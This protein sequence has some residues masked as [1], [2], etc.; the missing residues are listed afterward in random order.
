MGKVFSKGKMTEKVK[1]RVN[2]EKRAEITKIYEKSI[3]DLRKKIE[4]NSDFLTT[5]E[6][7]NFLKDNFE[8]LKKDEI[9]LDIED[10]KDHRKDTG[11]EINNEKLKDFEDLQD[12][13]Y[14]ALYKEVEVGKSLNSEL[15]K[16]INNN[17]EG[18][19]FIT[20]DIKKSVEKI[21]E[22]DTNLFSVSNK[23]LLEEKFK[24][25]SEKLNSKQRTE[26]SKIKVLNDTI[27][28]I[29]NTIL[30][31]NLEKKESN[32][33]DEVNKIIKRRK[34]IAAG[35]AQVAVATIIGAVNVIMYLIKQSETISPTNTTNPPTNTTKLPTN[36]TTPKPSTNTTKPPV[37]TDSLNKDIM[38]ILSLVTL[39]ISGCYMVRNNGVNIEAIRLEGCSNWYNNIE[40]QFF[41]G[42]PETTEKKELPDCSKKELC[43][44]PF[45]LK[46]NSN[47]NIP[48][49]EICT[50]SNSKEKLYKC[51]GTSI[52]DKDFVFY[53]YQFYTPNSV[54]DIINS[55]GEETDNTT[56]NIFIIVITVIGI[57]LTM[58]IIYFIMKNKVS[59]KKL[60][61]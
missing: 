55:L 11:Q 25:L 15:V 31:D 48:D 16:I 38:Y 19:K 32:I 7:N 4:T 58:L 41:C 21:Y 46:Q 14:D 30:F 45:C 6:I 22:K 10:Y 2:S 33:T 17:T 35:I 47:C 40:N 52:N 13:Y 20:Q 9:N 5:D 44:Y 36:T 43:N 29:T 23:A 1:N 61:K 3:N 42:C 49:A 28:D 26:D 56:P 27:D 8:T 51:N 34:N 24:K 18:Y 39:K 54:V 60:R 57:V 37:N 53:T 59:K 12:A 50:V